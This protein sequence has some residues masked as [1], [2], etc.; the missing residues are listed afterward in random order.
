MDTAVGQNGKEIEI[1]DFLDEQQLRKAPRDEA[2]AARGCLDRY[3]GFAESY[4]A[5]F[6]ERAWRGPLLVAG[7][8]FGTFNEAAKPGLRVLEVGIG[9]GLMAQEFKRQNPSCHVTGVDIS[10]AM[11]EKCREKGVA[12]ALVRANMDDEAAKLPFDD[13]AFDVAVSTGVLEC[14]KRPSVAIREMGR[15]LRPGGAFAF[16]V[17]RECPEEPRLDRLHTDDYIRQAAAE[18]GL[19]IGRADRIRAYYGR[20]DRTAAVYHTLYSG[21]KAPGL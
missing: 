5:T 6:A 18:A 7:R 16:S 10:M 1:R 15:L 8:I 12:D 20:A 17:F 19:R 9:T 2:G 21:A 13:G 11:L 4:D 14:M 3:A